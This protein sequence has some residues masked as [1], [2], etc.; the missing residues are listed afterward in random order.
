MVPA[1]LLRFSLKKELAMP[2]FKQLVCGTT[3]ALAIACAPFAT[4]SAGGYGYEHYH[5]WGVGRCLLGA[6]VGIATL[7]LVIASA[8]IEASVLEAPSYAPVPGYYAAPQSYYAPSVA[9][10][11]RPP[12][13][14]PAPRAYYAPRAYP[15]SAPRP[16]SYGGYGAYRAG[17]YGYPRR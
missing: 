14:Y 15:G 4:V 5:G 8:A 12:V 7:P 3:A 1:K 9:Y 13:Y 16:G 2:G 6:V 11:P 17:G 10:Y